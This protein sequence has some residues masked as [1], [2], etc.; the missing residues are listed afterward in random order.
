[1]N[2]KHEQN[3]TKTHNNQILKVNRKSQ[4]QPQG[5][6]EDSN[7]KAIDFPLETTEAEGH[8]A[9]SLKQWEKK[10]DQPWVL[11]PEKV[12]FKNENKT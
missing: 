1:M 5:K 9:K 6:H 4:T 12:S 2:Q 10:Y 8:G 7:V 3:Y 11:Y